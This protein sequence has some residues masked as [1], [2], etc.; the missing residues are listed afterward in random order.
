MV[1]LIGALSG[2]QSKGEQDQ[3]QSRGAA[4]P[5]SQPKGQPEPGPAAKADE[6]AA[7]PVA[8]SEVE[9]AIRDFEVEFVRE[10]NQGDSK[11]VAAHFTE[12]AEVVD[13]DGE[14]YQGRDVIAQGFAGLFA[15]NKGAKI[16]LEIFTIRSLSPDVA[17]E[18]GRSVVTPIEGAPHSRLYTV[19]YVKRDGRWLVSSIRDDPDPQVSPHERLKDLDWMI[20][21][22][23]DEGE[24]SIVR[25]NCRWSEDENYLLR[26]FT[27]QRQG[28]TVLSVSQRIG[29]DPLAR[30]IRSWDFDSAGG[31]GEGRWTRNGESW[32]IRHTGVQPE[33]KTASSTNTMTKE[34][35]DLVRWISTDRV[36]GDELL[37]DDISYVLVRVPPRPGSSLSDRPTSPASPNTRSQR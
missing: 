25:L 23:I 11:A 29:W 7:G 14:H 32:V 34:R 36:I 13:I 28:E 3:P 26:S 15:Q 6:D 20:G 27:V 8:L 9:K 17:Q 35:P 30:Q 22:W 5:R 31:Y 19:V 33:G 1:L 24:D 21:D 18:E 4:E 10:Y 12:D 37:P 16:A 2:L